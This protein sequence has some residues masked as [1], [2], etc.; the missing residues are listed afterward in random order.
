MKTST[1]NGSSKAGLISILALAGLST[2]LGLKVN[3][4]LDNSAILNIGDSFVGLKQSYSQIYFP[5]FKSQQDYSQNPKEYSNKNAFS[6]I[7]N[8]VEC[9]DGKLSINGYG[10]K[11]K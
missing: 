7:Y 8:L 3:R 6:T 11:E 2:A 4:A 10:S 9:K 5:K 1:K